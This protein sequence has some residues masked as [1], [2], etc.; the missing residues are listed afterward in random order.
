MRTIRTFETKKDVFN[1]IKRKFYKRSNVILVRGSTAKK[2]AKKFSDFDIEVYTKYLR[3]PY[4][5]IVF[6]REKPVLVSV[7]FQKYKKGKET[8]APSTIK[9]LYGKYNAK[10]KPDFS[11]EKYT[12][13]QKIRREC[14][15]L[16]DMFFKY[17]RTGN[18]RYL[19][20]VQKRIT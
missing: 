4:Y 3:K 18:K 6:I 13:K 19:E 10:L 2:P 5:E 8:N 9:V 15:I 17:L 11:K 12:P 1:Y 14:Q 16:L 20:F 7:Y